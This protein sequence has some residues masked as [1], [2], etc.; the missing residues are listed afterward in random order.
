[1]RLADAILLSLLISFSFGGCRTPE[2]SVPPPLR[3]YEPAR[4]LAT[5]ADSRIN[6]SSGLAASLIRPDLFWTHNDSGDGP[7]LYAFDRKGRSVGS[8]ELE[9]T[10]AE[11][12]EDM[13]ACRLDGRAYLLA[14]DVGD[15]SLKRRDYRLHLIAEPL[16][17]REAVHLKLKPEMTV[18]FRYE[19]GP[20]NCESVAVDGP[21]RTI[22][23]ISKPLRH[24]EAAEV[25]RLPLPKAPT[26]KLLIA[27]RI[28]R[29]AIPVPTAMDISVD[30]QRMVVI[31]Y[32]PAVWMWQRRHAAEP[33]AQ[34]LG[35][36]G[37]RVAEAPLRIQG[38]S[39][40]FGH[41]GHSLYL[42]S[43][44]RPAP[45]WYQAAR[46]PRITSND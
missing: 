8:V 23:L 22:V 36:P 40:C 29:L 25:Y 10:T 24:G 11:D 18:R 38:E 5:L 17:G 12:W 15:N 35:R 39:V 30:A 34:V 19:D 42:G 37:R 21:A 4:L 41:D 27:R 20:R 45:L 3:R 32:G 44:K 7:V 16:L 6:E 46:S 14:A 9:N 26:Q 28:G 31:G 13:A 43:E 1:M 2:P 33:W